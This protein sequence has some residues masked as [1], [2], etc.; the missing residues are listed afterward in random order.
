MTKRKI[1]WHLFFSI[2][3]V[4]LLLCCGVV[5]VESR[6]VN[7]FYHRQ[8]RQDLES[9]AQIMDELLLPVIIPLSSP[10]IDSLCKHLFAKTGTRFTLI[11]PD[12]TVVGDSERD[13]IKM[14]NHLYR[15]EVKMALGRKTGNA[16]RFSTTLNEAMMYVAIPRI[17][18]D[19]LVLI[20]RAAVPMT[21]IKADIRR[22][23]NSMLWFGLLAVGFALVITFWVSRWLSD[24]IRRL[25]DHVRLFASGDLSHRISPV[26]SGSYEVMALGEAMNS[27][28]RQLSDRISTVTQQRNEQQTILSSM[29]EGVIAVDSSEK[30]LFVNNAAMRILSLDDDFTYEGRW[31][32][33]IIRN[34][35]IC[36]FVE[37]SLVS[38]KTI[39][40]DVTLL[41]GDVE[42]IQ[43]HG[44]AI[45]VKEN[46][47]A[48]AVI[49]LND[50]TRL[51]KL[52][53]IR[54]D[55]VANVSH[56]LK[57]PL[58]S[59]K[60]SI[61]TIID[62]AIENR[63]EAMRFLNIARNQTDRLN[64]I[65]DDLLTLSRIEQQE[66]ERQIPREIIPL[67][68]VIYSARS[69]CESKIASKNMH[70]TVRGSD[71]IIASVNSSLLE[72]AV[73][74]LVDNAIKYSDPDKSITIALGQVNDSITISVTDQG[75]GI[76]KEHLAR[77]FERFYRVDK[78]R[79][80]SQGGT[81]LGLSIV[82]HIIHLHDGSVFVTS[83]L[84]VGST[85]TIT[86][87]SLST[88]GK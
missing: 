46:E 34:S 18:S 28:A 72:Q 56:E 49:V 76:S 43:M 69:A 77:L 48:G 23:Q 11:L 1:F 7:N 54:R 80:S 3:T 62:G 31:I 9:R 10:A 55:F 50:V 86:L 15:P 26:G 45:H 85:F 67:L 44:T 70:V 13:P 68:P 41:K 52:E 40:L 32:R 64:T 27:M 71:A 25:A 74:N 79:S 24:P 33:E 2:L 8:I 22:L 75:I 66:E 6:A 12:G 42:N 73:V 35:E 19:S 17:V 81:G 58:T 83:Q 4:T 82:K 29:T 16:V 53:T 5:F 57:T 61:E 14:E 65:V 51:K 88:T 60:G 84:G 37:Q 20:I 87:P 47:I 30:V 36:S 63:S 21:A 78:A 38:K 59:V 39:E